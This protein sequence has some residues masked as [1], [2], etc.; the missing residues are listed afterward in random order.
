MNIRK[1]KMRNIF[2]KVFSRSAHG[3]FSLINIVLS[4]FNKEV[5]IFDNSKNNSSVVKTKEYILLRKSRIESVSKDT[6]IFDDAMLLSNYWRVNEERVDNQEYILLDK[7]KINSAEKG[8]VKFDNNCLLTTHQIVG[9]DTV[10]FSDKIIVNRRSVVF[11]S[12]ALFNDKKALTKLLNDTEKKVF[13]VNGSVVN[14]NDMVSSFSSALEYKSLLCND[15]AENKH[16]DEVRRAE[17]RIFQV[18]EQFFYS[19]GCVKLGDNKLNLYDPNSLMILMNEL[20]ITEDYFFESESNNPLIIDCGSNFGLSLFYYKKMYPNSRII[21]F[22]PLSSMRKVLQ[23]NID[24]NGWSNVVLEPYALWK[25]DAEMTFQVPNDD[26]MAGSLTERRKALDGT[27]NEE[28]VIC[29]RL[30]TYLEN[31][32]DFLKLDIEGAELEVLEESKHLLGNVNYIFCEYHHLIDD[33]R[34][35]RIITILEDAGFDVNVTKS[36]SYSRGTKYRPMKYLNDKG[37]LYSASIFC[38]N[39]VVTK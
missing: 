20:L 12:W 11:L 33:P 19:D 32:V 29:K 9:N 10:E 14:L 3:I 13:I 16:F 4:K 22:E 27:M 28:K 5:V 38:K 23:N 39:K 8:Y 15:Y 2:A 21:S 24:S 34:L 37:Y 18:L 1:S 35:G 7:T 30:S 25:E 31:K 17:N 36:Y 6:V 26:S